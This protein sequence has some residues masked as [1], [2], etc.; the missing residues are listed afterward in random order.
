MSGME[1]AWDD[2]DTAPGP[3][4]TAA[5]NPVAFRFVM[6]NNGDVNLTNVT[7]SDVPAIGAFYTERGLTIP[8]TFP[9]LTLATNVS[10]NVYGSLPWAQGQQTGTARATGTP[11]MGAPVSDTDPT[12]YSG[13]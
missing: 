12:Y 6:T 13:F 11:P 4:R 2:A 8:A 3:S 1:P 5:Q 9:I 7:L 10:V